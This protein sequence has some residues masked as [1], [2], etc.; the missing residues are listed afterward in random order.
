MDYSSFSDETLLRLIARSQES[1][2]SELYDRY[3]RLVYSVALS[4]LSDPALAEEVTQD[5]FV[6]VWEKA[7]TYRPEGGRV[8]TWL[9]SIARHRSIDLFR[10]SRTRHEDMQVAWQE[11]ELVDLRDGNNVEWE[12]DLKQRQKHIRWAVSQLPAEQKIAVGMAF[13]MG[14]THPEIADALGEPL[15]TVKTR[16][17]LGMQKLR[18]LLQDEQT[19]QKSVG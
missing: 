17:R 8:I 2:L 10:R 14:L 3:S 7:Q 12:A 5:V 6:R 18:L 11:I 19:E 16:I 1:A 9:T 15:G 13:F 4:T